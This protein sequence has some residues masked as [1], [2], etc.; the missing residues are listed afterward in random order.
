METNTP[1]MT[2][3]MYAELAGQPDPQAQPDPVAPQAQPQP[4]PQTP[5][6]VEQAKELLGLSQTEDTVSQLQAQMQSMQEDKIRD[7]M[8]AKYP[9]IPYEIVEKEIAKVEAI[10]PQFAQAMRTTPDGMDMAYRASQASMRPQE[11][12][13]NLTDGESGGGQGENLDEVVRKGNASDYDLGQ[14]II[15]GK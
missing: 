5:D 3:E 14:F 8:S 7:S 15:G 13:D 9:D 2:P 4:D 12:P 11:K 1:Q 10:N 6:E